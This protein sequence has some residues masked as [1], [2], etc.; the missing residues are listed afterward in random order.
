MATHQWIEDLLEVLTHVQRLRHQRGPQP[1]RALRVEATRLVGQR[2]RKDYDTIANAYLR[3][4]GYSASEIDRAVEDWLAGQPARLHGR[5]RQRAEGGEDRRRIDEFFGYLAAEAEADEQLSMPGLPAGKAP[6][7]ARKG[8]PRRPVLV[9]LDKDVA[10]VFPDDEAVNA[11]LRLLI[12]AARRAQ[13]P[14]P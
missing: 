4:L 2:R 5:I 7:G 8:K 14:A 6:E 10:R 13:G 3:M 9:V 12:Q 11:A 1:V